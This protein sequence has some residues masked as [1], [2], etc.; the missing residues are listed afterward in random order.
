MLHICEILKDLNTLEKI[1]N[2]NT[3]F[4]FCVYVRTYS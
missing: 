2:K 3:T 1:I 4:K